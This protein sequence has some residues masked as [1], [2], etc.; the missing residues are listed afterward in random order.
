M[1]TR[2]TRFLD[3]E[4]PFQDVA[5]VLRAADKFEVIYALKWAKGRL[6]LLFPDDINDIPRQ[7][8]PYAAQAVRL[9]EDCGVDFIIK[10]AMYDLLRQTT[11]GFIS[12]TD[13]NS[14]NGT[15]AELTDKHVF[16]LIKARMVL[17]EAWDDVVCNPAAFAQDGTE[18]SNKCSCARLYE[19]NDQDE[20]KSRKPATSK[21]E[22]FSNA[23]FSRS[24]ADGAKSIFDIGRLDIMHGMKLLINASWDDLECPTCLKIRK[25]GWRTKRAAIWDRLDG[26]LEL[27]T[28]IHD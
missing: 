13:R 4:S 11:H 17:L 23:V 3:G 8:R 18:P 12:P 19:S 16:Q 27:V 22:V 10:P 14:G 21:W 1:L 7:P 15:F 28:Y 5:P 6:E 26:P 9:G 20:S 24:D 25:R 2:M